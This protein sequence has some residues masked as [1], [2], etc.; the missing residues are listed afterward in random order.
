MFYS[1]LH[2]ESVD[3]EKYPLCSY[4]ILNIIQIMENSSLGAQKDRLLFI[5]L[6]IRISISILGM[7][8]QYNVVYYDTGK[9]L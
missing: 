4:F 5:K 6:Y 7:F 2:Y 8:F 3:I 9:L 1:N